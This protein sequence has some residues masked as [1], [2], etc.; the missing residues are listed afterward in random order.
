MDRPY[1]IPFFAVEIHSGGYIPHRFL[2]MDDVSEILDEANFAGSHI[3][4]L[5]RVPKVRFVAASCAIRKQ[6]FHLHLRVMPERDVATTIPLALIPP[7]SSFPES[8]LDDLDFVVDTQESTDE[9]LTIS[10]STADGGFCIPVATVLSASDVDVGFR[11]EV[12][13]VGQSFDMIERWQNHKQ[14]NKAVSILSD[15]EALRL[16]FIHFQF[17]GSFQ[18]FGDSDYYAML[19]MDRDSAEFRDR[20]SVLEQALIHFYRPILNSQ[21]VDGTINTA[22]FVRL[23][24]RVGLKSVGLSIGMH[25]HAFDF[26]SPKQVL[27]TEVATLRP[28]QGKPVFTDGL[29]C[30]DDFL[31]QG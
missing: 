20:I 29:Q 14:V 24:E 12:I 8:E 31:D 25:G 3:Y 22:P 16:Y 11:P 28:E 23:V 4:Y 6:T 27:D 13:Y 1:E 30:V 10:S 17:F 2:F 19:A 21:H 18:S 15:H 26:W 7:F 5:A 9:M